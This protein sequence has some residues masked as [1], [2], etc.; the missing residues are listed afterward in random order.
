MNQI[1]LQKS[2]DKPDYFIATVNMNIIDEIEDLIDQD[3]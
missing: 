2:L 3:N 1:K